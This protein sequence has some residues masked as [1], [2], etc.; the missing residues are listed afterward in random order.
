MEHSGVPKLL[1]LVT[2]RNPSV[3]KV[4]IIVCERLN[5]CGKTNIMREFILRSNPRN[6][7]VGSDRDESVVFNWKCA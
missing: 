3:D 2:Y 4:V 1:G 5:K 7:F 6:K